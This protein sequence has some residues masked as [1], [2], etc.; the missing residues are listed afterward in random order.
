M[1][2]SSS[3]NA[4]TSPTAIQLFFALTNVYSQF[5]FKL[6]TDGS[7][8][9]IWHRI[10]LDMCKGAK[11]HGH[12][13]DKSKPA[14]DDDEDWEAIDSRI[15]SWFY[16]TFDA[17][18]L[19]IISSDNCT[20]KDL[21]DK[22][23]EFF[24]NNK[25]SRMLQLQ[26][27]FRN[28][29]HQGHSQAFFGS[30]AT[31]RHAPIT[32]PGLLGVPSCNPL[33]PVTPHPYYYGQPQYQ[34]PVSATSQFGQPMQQ[35]MPVLPSTQPSF[36]G[37]ASQYGQPQYTYLSSVFQAKFVEAPQDNNSYMDFG[38]T[39]HMTFNQDLIAQRVIISRHVVFDETHFLFPDFQPRRSSK[40]D[41]SFDIDDSLPSLSP[42]VNTPSPPPNNGSSTFVSSSQSPP[43]KPSGTSSTS[44]A[45]TA[46]SSLPMNT[47]S[48]TCSLKAKQ[49]FNLSF[50]SDISPIP[51]STAQAI[52]DPHWRAAMDSE[53]SALLSNH[54]WDL[55]P[56]PSHANIVGSRWLYRYNFDN[57]GRLRRYKGRLV[58]QVLSISISHNWPIHQ[59]DVK[60]V[61][62]HG[63]LTETIYVSQPLCY[64]DSKLPDHVFRLRKA[65]YG[66]KQAP[67]EC[68]PADTK[69]KLPADVT[70][71]RV[72]R[73]VGDGRPSL[74]PGSTEHHRERR[75]GCGHARAKRWLAGSSKCHGRQPWSQ[76]GGGLRREAAAT[77]RDGNEWLGRRGRLAAVLSTKRNTG[78]GRRRAVLVVVPGR[79]D[80][81]PRRHRPWCRSPVT[82]LFGSDRGVGRRRLGELRELAASGCC[83]T[84]M[85]GGGAWSVDAAVR[86]LLAALRLSTAGWRVTGAIPAKDKGK[87][88]ITVVT[89]RTSTSE[90][91]ETPD[92][93]D[94]IGPQITETLHQILPGLFA[95]MKD[96]LL[97]A[98]DER[99]EA[100]FTARGSGTSSTSQG[101]SRAST[102]KD[103]MACQPPHFEG[104]KD[105]IACYRWVA[106]VEG[107]FRTSCCL[108]A[109]K[110]VYAVNML[111]NAGKDWWGL[112]LKSRT[113][114]QSGTMTW[115]EFKALLD[116]EFS[117]RVEKERITA[118]FLN[119]RQTTETVNEITA[120][121]LEKS[122]F[123]PDY[124]G[125]EEVKMYRF[126]QALKTEIQEFVA[127]AK[128]QTFNELVEVARKQE[129]YMEEQRQ[130]KRKA[131]LA[132]VTG[133]SSMSRGRVFQLT[134]NEAK[135]EP[136]VVTGIFPVNRRPALVLFDSGATWSFVSNAFC[137][138]F[139]LERGRL[140]RP[141]AIDVAAEEVRICEDVYRSCTIVI[142]GVSFSINLIPTSMNGVDVI[143]GVDWMFR[144]HG[145]LDIAEQLVH[146]QNPSGGELI[147]YGEGRKKQLAFRS[148]AKA[149]RYL[150]HGCAGYLAYAMTSST[151][152]K[153]L[154]VADVPVVSDYPDVFP[155]DL[156]GIPP[157][158]E[159]DFGIDLVPG[160]A[161]VART[162][163]WLAPPELQELSNQLQ[164]L[165]AKGF[166][167]PSSS[168]W[169]API[170]FV[171]KKD[172]SLRMCIDYQE[173]NKV[174]IK[175]RYPLP[176]ID[177]LFDQLQGVAWFSKI[178]LR[179]GYHQLKVKEADVSKTAFRTRYGHFEFLV[180]PF[181]ITNAPAAFMDLM[182]RVCRPML[183]KSVIVFID[184]ILIYSKTKEEHVTHLREVLEVLR[185]ERLYAKFSKCAL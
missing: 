99:I 94:V 53:M 35:S 34:N 155:E 121:F 28:P 166:I 37:H 26:E 125:S 75:R 66:L 185:R 61:F 8:Y 160:A 29:G 100:T 16:S 181:G 82:W 40:D 143:V 80:G 142:H 72:Y 31:P 12:V 138:G 48:C 1:T 67:R 22:L 44:S 150:R 162:P 62:L 52:C 71:A 117:P 3:S 13:T 109:M 88:P 137:K 97:A 77:A 43:T 47:H 151:E 69:T 184:D 153:K 19:Q 136:D 21:W 129:M 84:A 182:N 74:M 98:V 149:G 170:L 25:M 127:I 156:P 102:F 65:L 68:T 108:D 132:L 15:K 161:P 59:L 157:E 64:I 131:E 176:R 124:V 141:V 41:D 18:L 4:I 178:D 32:Q 122:L 116:E 81:Y 103:F 119:L 24:L 114:E 90:E 60:N 85:W 139:Q 7:K 163:Y 51:R 91:Q 9:K 87:A 54:M 175:N 130:G 38:A 101:Q 152:E 104:K 20:A 180:M 95:Q 2:T 10:F 39:R 167:H 50:T 93:L 63:D 168:P 36:G 164:E 27:Q 33:P 106:A 133:P 14:G 148:V 144:N 56:K 165:S 30:L 11:V 159:V 183:D 115:E 70:A 92:L 179:S 112:I 140:D 134:A 89:R 171:K 96:E 6:S 79:C 173:L 58:A 120:Q 105:P 110:V 169:G 107:A 86:Q 45:P 5:S 158:R 118:E 78:Y 111:R 46:P 55:F 42:I 17:N 135:V 172:G 174:T 83:C 126:R 76:Y 154:A 123:C 147:V 23:D 113:E 128:Y 73:F 177:D 146:I 145:V 49:I 57:N